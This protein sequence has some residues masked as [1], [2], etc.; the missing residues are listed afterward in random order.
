M[1]TN[2]EDMVNSNDGG[3]FNPIRAEDDQINMDMD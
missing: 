2:T 3:D 1:G